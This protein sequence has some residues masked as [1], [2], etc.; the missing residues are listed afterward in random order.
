M[1]LPIQKSFREFAH[2]L[3]YIGRLIHKDFIIY[4]VRIANNPDNN[5]LDF[6]LLK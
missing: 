1:G 3:E 5:L 4:T 6:I 2:Q